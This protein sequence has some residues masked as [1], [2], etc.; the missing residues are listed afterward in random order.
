MSSN[1]PCN[2]NKLNLTCRTNLTIRAIA[3][4]KNTP[5]KYSFVG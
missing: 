5:P 3:N 2:Q 1:I 4:T